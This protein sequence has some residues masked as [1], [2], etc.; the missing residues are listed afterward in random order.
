M[1]L[2]SNVNFFVVL[3][4]SL[5]TSAC[6]VEHVAA[7]LPAILTFQ[8]AVSV[9]VTVAVTDFP[10]SI[11]LAFV[12]IVALGDAITICGKKSTSA[13]IKYFLFITYSFLFKCIFT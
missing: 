10:F 2:H 8:A 9:R 3:F 4:P 12:L 13:I 11:E 5:V 7:P 1:D 6:L